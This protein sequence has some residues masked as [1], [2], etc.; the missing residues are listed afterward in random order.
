MNTI[1]KNVSVL[2]AAL[3]GSISGIGIYKNY[4]DTNSNSNHYISAKLP[5]QHVNFKGSVP[6]ATIDFTAAAENTVPTVVHVKTSYQAKGAYNSPFFDP[7]GKRMVWL[8]TL[9]S[10]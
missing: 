5:V 8:M 6:T 7:F 10:K 4:F 9:P 2:V 1:R 3:I